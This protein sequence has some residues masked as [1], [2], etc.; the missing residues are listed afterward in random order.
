MSAHRGSCL[1]LHSIWRELLERDGRGTLDDAWSTFRKQLELGRELEIV[2][3][4]GDPIEL[5]GD[6]PDDDDEPFD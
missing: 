6:Y 3:E 2:D 4:R 5:G 1:C